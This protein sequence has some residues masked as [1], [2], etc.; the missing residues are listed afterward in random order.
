MLHW[1]LFIIIGAQVYTQEP[2]LSKDYCEAW[3]Q[4]RAEMLSRIFDDVSYICIEV[5]VH[6]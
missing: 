4:H 6:E 5:P 3:G 2:Q 1:M